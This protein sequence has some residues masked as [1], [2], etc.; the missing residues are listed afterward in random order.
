[1]SGHFGPASR[2]KRAPSAYIREHLRFTIQ[3]L[4]A[5]AEVRQL[6]EVV[7]Q[8]ESDELLLYASDY[9][10]VHLADPMSFLSGLPP[11][12]ARR[13]GYENARDWYRW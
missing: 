10:H 7:E 9:P 8:L 13:I 11:D 4:D 2:N 6:H 1:M 5:P 12:L 3:P